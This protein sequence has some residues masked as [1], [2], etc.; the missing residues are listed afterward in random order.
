MKELYGY[1]NKLTIQNTT[2]I[3]IKY[4]GCGSHQMDISFEIDLEAINNFLKQFDISP[5]VLDNE[6][7][8]KPPKNKNEV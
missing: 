3:S 1:E 7:K 6:H 4:S 5:I 8:R 2:N